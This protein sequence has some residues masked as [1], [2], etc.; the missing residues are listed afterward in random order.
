[1]TNI[2]DLKIGQKVWWFSKYGELKGGDKGA[3]VTKIA[4]KSHECDG[5]WYDSF[6]CDIEEIQEYEYDSVEIP[7]KNPDVTRHQLINKRKV[8]K[9]VINHYGVSIQGNQIYNKKP[10]KNEFMDDSVEF[11]HDCHNEDCDGTIRG[12][13][14]CNDDGE[15]TSFGYQ[16]CDKCGWNQAS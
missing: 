1:M 10:T 15:I 13:G 5:F 12:N 14:W 7:C 2:N 9:V 11:E 3:I 8:D 16:E 4:P 6:S